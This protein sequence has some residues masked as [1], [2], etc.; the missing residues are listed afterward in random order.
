MKVMVLV[1]AS[2]DSE[3]GIMPSQALL[4][5]MGQFNEELVN[6]GIMLAGEGLHPSSKGVR[7]EFSGKNRTIVDGPFAETKELVAGYW[8]WNVSSMQEAITWAK[9]CPNPMLEDSTLEIRPVFDVCDFG[10]AM[11]PE[12]KEQEAGFRA[13]SLGLGTLRFEDAPELLI[14]GMNESY[15]F[16]SRTQIPQ[17]WMKFAPSI[18]QIPGQVGGSSYGVCWNYK[19]EC[20]FDYLTG[21]E[22]SALA[23]I[24]KE[25]KQLRMDAQRYAIFTHSGHVSAIPQTIDN[26]WK[27]WLPNTGLQVAE[28][29]CF[30]RYTE[31]FNPQTGR[32]GTE[33]WIP[34]KH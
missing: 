31:Q 29:P 25:W 32:G 6:A 5:E 30:E 28:S 8:M 12:L 23:S 14:A 18:G 17:Q 11:T 1:K 4:T 15:T 24:P 7:I 3:A 26:I 21:V 27:K 13:Q 22:V 20:G 16:E 34:I 10:D 19:P 9:R 33:I 2:K